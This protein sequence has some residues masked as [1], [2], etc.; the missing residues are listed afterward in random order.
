MPCVS[1]LSQLLRVNRTI[2]LGVFLFQLPN[3]RPEVTLCDNLCVP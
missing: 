2:L 3:V 1:V